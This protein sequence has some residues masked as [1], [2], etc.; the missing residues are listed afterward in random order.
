[1]DLYAG[2]QYHEEIFATIEDG[3]EWNTLLAWYKTKTKIFLT[4]RYNERFLLLQDEL[5]Y[6]CNIYRNFKGSAD[7]LAILDYLNTNG[8]ENAY[9]DL[10]VKHVCYHEFL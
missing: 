6:K 4:P 2:K 3:I 8:L 9:R 10:S 1:M 7:K 5:R